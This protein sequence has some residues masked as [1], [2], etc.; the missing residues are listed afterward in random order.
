MTREEKEMNILNIINHTLN[1]I[2]NC[3]TCSY[4]ACNNNPKYHCYMFERKPLNCKAYKPT[5]NPFEVLVN[6]LINK[7]IVF[8][9]TKP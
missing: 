9:P 3:I 4:K 8:L 5:K 6:Q 2:G 1:G 7:E